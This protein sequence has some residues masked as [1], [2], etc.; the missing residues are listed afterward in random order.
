[1][2]NWDGVLLDIDGVL[3]VGDQALPGAHAAIAA[4]RGAGVPLE[5]VT[6]TTSRPRH[7]IAARLQRLGFDLVDDDILTPARM[8]VEYCRAQGYERVAFVVPHALKIDLAELE[9][10]APGPAVDA[11]ILGDLGRAFNY[12]VINRTFRSVLSGAELIALQRNRYWRKPEGLVVDAG[13]YV[14]GLEYATG[15]PAT[16]VGKP[17]HAFFET[18]ARELGVPHERIVMVGDDLEA[19]VGGAIDHGLAGVLVRTG[20]FRADELAQSAITPSLVVDS[21]ADVPSLVGLDAV[22]V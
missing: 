14:A 5:F 2:A 21:I 12:D 17:S 10:A 1:M 15:R 19:D 13:F 8:A 7:A 4:L 22:R 11:V 18:A 20:K 3:H 16:V 9:E 6:N